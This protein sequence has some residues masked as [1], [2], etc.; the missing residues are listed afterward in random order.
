MERGLLAPFF[1]YLI[2]LEENYHEQ[3]NDNE[4]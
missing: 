2:I 3:G 4:T 1:F